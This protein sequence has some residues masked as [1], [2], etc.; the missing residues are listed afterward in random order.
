MKKKLLV[1]MIGC[2]MATTILSG[3]TAPWEKEAT[4]KESTKSDDEDKSTNKKQSKD[5]DEEDDEVLTSEKDKKH[6]EDNDD[7]EDVVYDESEDVI[8]A[9]FEAFEDADKDKLESVFYKKSSEYKNNISTNYQRAKELNGDIDIDTKHIELK[10]AGY[11]DAEEIFDDAGFKYD[12]AEQYTVNVPLTQVKDG[13]E[14][15]LIDVYTVYTI[16]AGD[17]WYIGY[18]NEEDIIILDDE[19][20]S[21]KKDDDNNISKNPYAGTKDI[22]EYHSLSEL[23]RDYDPTYE[24]I[25]GNA[26][27]GVTCTIMYNTIFLDF[28][29]DIK[30]KKTWEAKE[31]L[32][33]AGIEDEMEEAFRPVITEIEDYTGWD[34]AIQMKITD[35]DGNYIMTVDVD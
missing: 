29:I 35:L 28:A 18:L 7:V 21:S 19:D 33:D 6:S 23:Y 15:D 16:Q 11:K 8:V 13:V 17:S 2:L 31:T 3:C 24:T 1:L 27:D 20:N 30:D 22:S 14:Y 34:V 26:P 10:Y 9:F 5:D 4:S 25:L 32:I 12:D